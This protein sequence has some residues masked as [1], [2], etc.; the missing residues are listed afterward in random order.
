MRVLVAGGAGFIGSNF[1][2]RSLDLYEGL[3]FTVLDSLTYAGDLANLGG[4]LDHINFVKGDIRNKDL[5]EELTRANDVVINF[6]AETHNDNSLRT[7]EL[8]VDVNVMGTL[9][10]IQAALKYSKRF[11]QISTDEV[12]GDLPIESHSEFNSSSPYRPSS[13]YS[14]SKASADH[15]VRS[16]VRSFKLQATISNCTNNYGMFQHPEK[17]IPNTIK[18]AL[19]G[20]KPHVYGLGLNVRDW[21]HVFDHI[22]GI[23]EVLNKGEI[24][25]TYLFGGRQQL[26]NIAVVQI[27]L[28]ALDLPED[29]VEF[30][31]D[32][33]GHDQRYALDISEAADALGWEPKAPRLEEYMPSLIE[34]YRKKLQT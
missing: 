5:V 9:N 22:D 32:R 23:W 26:S 21:I 33:P 2:K 29:H 31:T 10:L 3:K 27:I 7:P 19:G 28:R 12:Y 1:V 11:H 18:L 14:A 20:K 24:G 15:L 4:A 34:F 13:P 16:W 30:V 17:L 8:F 25:E 6:A